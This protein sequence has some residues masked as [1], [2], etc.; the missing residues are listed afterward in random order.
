MKI[1]IIGVGNIL[2]CDDGIG[3]LT[4]EVLKHCYDFSYSIDIIDGGTLG[5]GLVNY[6]S[7]YDEIIILDT[8]SIDDEVGSIY[9]FNSSELL[10]FDDYKNTAHEVEVIDMIRSS[11]LLE[12]CANIRI[13]GIVPNDINSVTIGLSDKLSIYFESY[14]AT[15]LKQLEKLDIKSNK[16]KE[17]DPSTMLEKIITK[18]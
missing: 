3:V 11:K 12:N 14:L 8:I 4:T 5:I 18:R 16:I 6:F 10:N 1:A 7:I 2:F 9:S 15:V 13:I 17:Y